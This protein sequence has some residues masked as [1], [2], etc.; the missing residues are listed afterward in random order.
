VRAVL[1]AAWLAA[2]LSLPACLPNTL[3]D[4]EIQARIADAK[5]SDTAGSGQDVAVGPGCG[6]GKIEGSEQCDPGAV[7][8]GGCDQCQRR[9]VLD[10]GSQTD[11]VKTPLADKYLISDK[12]DQSYSTWFK[13]SAVPP[14]GT[15]PFLMR[16]VAVSVKEQ[17]AVLAG[18]ARASDKVDSVYP[19]CAIYVW[20]PAIAGQPALVIDKLVVNG[21]NE[22]TLNAWH[23]MRC[24]LTNNAGKLGISVDGSPLTSEKVDFNLP[25]TTKASGALFAFGA[26]PSLL[27][28]KSFTGQL[29][30][31]QVAVNLPLNQQS[32]VDR[33]IVDASGSLGLFH[34]DGKEGDASV[35]DSAP[36]AADAGQ[37]T[38]NGKDFVSQNAPLHFSAED[39]YGFGAAGAQCTAAPKAPWCP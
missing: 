14:P 23:H 29:D 16:F 27:G 18:I 9:H 12:A 32:Q 34:L 24:V 7:S 11:A 21:K 19:I 15:M 25:Q 30:E 6:N 3:T 26:L 37:V 39:C 8:C 22:V 36:N 5:T 10:V 38:W 1:R 35:Q 28:T 31:V 4:Q 13:L 2:L 33:R 17:Y 20:G